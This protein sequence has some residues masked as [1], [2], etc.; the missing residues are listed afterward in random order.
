MVAVPVRGPCVTAKRTRAVC[1]LRISRINRRREPAP[2]RMATSAPTQWD[3]AT[4]HWDV[5]RSRFN[6]KETKRCNQN[7]AYQARC[8]RPSGRPRP[9]SREPTAG[10]DQHLRSVVFMTPLLAPANRVDPN[11]YLKTK[12]ISKPNGRTHHTKPHWTI[13]STVR[14]KPRRQLCDA[15]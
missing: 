9:G 15:R 7:V 2:P 6:E 8:G 10:F 3:R 14:T 13:H 12:P 11:T 5:W 4:S 1:R